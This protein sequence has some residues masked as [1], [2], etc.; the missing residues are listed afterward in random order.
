MN[1]VY[2]DDFAEVTTETG[3]IYVSKKQITH[4]ETE[5]VKSLGEEFQAVVIY[6]TGGKVY[7][8]ETLEDFFTNW[9]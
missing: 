7:T 9:H 4:I 5:K 3:T 8:R 6:T 1:T 2:P